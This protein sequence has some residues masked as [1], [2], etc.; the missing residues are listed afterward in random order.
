MRETCQLFPKLVFNCQPWVVC[1]ST[2]FKKRKRKEKEKTVVVSVISVCMLHAQRTLYGGI[3]AAL[4]Y[5]L[6]TIVY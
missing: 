5:A 6:Y 3:Y 1:L 4:A 2:D